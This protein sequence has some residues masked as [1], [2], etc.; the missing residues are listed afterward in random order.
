MVRARAVEQSNTH[1]T[2]H[3]EK[4]WKRGNGRLA[5]HSNVGNSAVRV[6][7]EL[8]GAGVDDRT[9][10]NLQVIDNFGT[11]ARATRNDELQKSSFRACGLNYGVCVHRGGAVEKSLGINCNEG[12]LVAGTSKY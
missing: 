2:S 12:C 4:A 10:D 5:L 7:L 6:R 1:L 11:R 3:D 9:T 8:K